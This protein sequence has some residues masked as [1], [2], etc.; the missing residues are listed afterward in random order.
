MNR[1]IS[2]IAVYVEPNSGQRPTF[3]AAAKLAAEQDATVTGVYAIPSVYTTLIGAADAPLPADVINQYEETSKQ[4]AEHLQAEFTQVMEA[5]NVRHVW[6]IEKDT[7]EIAVSEVFRYADVGMVSQPRNGQ[8]YNQRQVINQILLRS[9]RPVLVIPYIG[10]RESIG[11]RVLVGW[12]GGAQCTRAVHDALPVLVDSDWVEVISIENDQKDSLGSNVPV[13]EHL[14]RHG[15]EVRATTYPETE[16]DPGSVLLN[17]ASD[18]GADMIVAGAWGHSRARE[19]I[20]GGTTR[21]LLNN[22]T[23]P[24]WLSH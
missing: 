9:G 16:L 12:D 7:P 21:T 15:V 1:P 20:F 23:V 22:M 17:C 11:E 8:L 18:H 5:A 13:S 19:Y 3:E 6:R 14:A 10:A 4:R 24:V 2:D